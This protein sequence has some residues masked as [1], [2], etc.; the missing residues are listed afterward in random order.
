MELAYATMGLLTSGLLAMAGCDAKESSTP[1]LHTVSGSVDATVPSEAQTAVIIWEV[2]SGSPDYVYKF[3]EG[4]VTGGRFS[5][6]LPSDPPAEAINSYGLGVGLVAVLVPGVALPDGKI[7]A[8]I[9]A[10]DV[11]AGVS[12]D[13]SVI[14]RAETFDFGG[15]TP[16]ADFWPLGFPPGLSCGAC[17]PRPD[18]GSFDGFAPAACDGI[19]VT[20]FGTADVCNWT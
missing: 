8:G 4:A 14:W 6:V 2:S 16:P 12:P 15:A 17:T 18:G 20:S 13:R 7:A 9:A 3:G 5:I 1:A 11:L 19:Q 10:A